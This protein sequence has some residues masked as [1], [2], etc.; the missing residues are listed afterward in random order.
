MKFFDE[1]LRKHELKLPRKT[2]ENSDT[3]VDWTD[4][5]YPSFYPLIHYNPA[6]IKDLEKQKFVDVN[7]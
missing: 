7:L 4:Y 3:Y 6:N 2:E 1:I 5:N